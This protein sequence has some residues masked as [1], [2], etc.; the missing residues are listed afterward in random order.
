MSIGKNNNDTRIMNKKRF[1]NFLKIGDPKTRNSKITYT[2]E[3]DKLNL[4]WAS[5]SIHL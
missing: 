1:R 2:L 3:R 5:N 4:R